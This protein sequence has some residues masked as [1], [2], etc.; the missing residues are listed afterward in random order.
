MYATHTRNFF[1][2][3]CDLV[4]PIGSSARM[5]KSNF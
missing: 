3:K 4:G 2:A 5:N 1:R